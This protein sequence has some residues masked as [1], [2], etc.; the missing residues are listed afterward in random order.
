MTAA[1]LVPWGVLC[2]YWLMLESWAAGGHRGKGLPGILSPSS[3]LFCWKI[4]GHSCPPG[5]LLCSFPV[6]SGLR[7]SASLAVSHADH[8]LHAPSVTQRP[9]RKDIRD[10]SGARSNPG[11]R[12]QYSPR[13]RPGALLRPRRLSPPTPSLQQPWEPGPATSTTKELG[14]PVQTCSDTPEAWA[15]VSLPTES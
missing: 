13:Q 5:A 11:N 7:P 6:S 3:L 4:L 14:H 12:E 9:S 8:G 2:R 15:I 10:S 1:C